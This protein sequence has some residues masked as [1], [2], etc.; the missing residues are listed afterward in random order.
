M[1]RR[2]GDEG[3]ACEV[4]VMDSEEMCGNLHIWKPAS[5][6]EVRQCFFRQITKF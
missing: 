5:L 4:V 3:L 2:R 6:P 1:D